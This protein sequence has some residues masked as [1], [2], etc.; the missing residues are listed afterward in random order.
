MTS[1]PGVS[2]A[3]IHPDHQAVVD[4]LETRY[5]ALGLRFDS[6]FAGSIPVQASG[7]IGRR[8][9][10]FRFRGDTAALQIGSP[11]YKRDASY[12]KARHR[13]ARR[14]LRR[15][16]DSGF[17]GLHGARL[18]LRRDDG[19][20]RHPSRLSRYAVIGDVT[21]ERY[22]GELTQEA[23]EALFNRLMADL[24]PARKPLT[25]G[26]QYRLIAKGQRSWPMGSTGVI[27]KRSK[28]R[29]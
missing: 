4:R 14:A 3:R 19:F 17:F 11:D 12:R 7:R 20:S 16:D 18:D 6:G 23:A 13:K 10:Y 21:G 24:A 29:R 5:A 25:S 28:R 8:F 2:H 22:A 15:N 9:F 26:L 1:H 27:R